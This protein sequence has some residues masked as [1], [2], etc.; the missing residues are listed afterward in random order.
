[1]LSESKMNGKERKEG[2]R[3]KRRENT[4]KQGK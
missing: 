1:M 2:K 3:K 4:E